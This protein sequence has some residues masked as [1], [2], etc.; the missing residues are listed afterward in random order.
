MEGV[1]TA[2]LSPGLTGGKADD[3][4]L[5]GLIEHQIAE[6]VQGLVV[7]AAAGEFVLHTYDERRRLLATVV[8]IVGGRVPVIAGILTPGT[9]EAEEEAVMAQAAGADG[10]MVL[11]PFFVSPSPRHLLRH[12]HS[13][14][15]ASSLPIILYNNPGRTAIN[16]DADLLDE[17]S[18]LEN[19]VGIKECDRDLG[20]VAQKMARTGERLL[21]LSGDDDLLLPF[22]SIGGVG[23]VMAGSNLMPALCVRAYRAFR[24]GDVV[25][26]RRIFG[27]ILKVVALYKGPDHPGPLK[28]LVDLIGYGVGEAR[29]PLGGLSPAVHSEAE[30]VLGGLGL[31][32]SQDTALSQAR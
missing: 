19:V 31:I 25:E 13:V 23:A 24:R 1:L 7:S 20:R 6:G 15:L 26:A 3:R 32:P 22:L 28:M 10:L 17:L 16:M 2:L 5:A 4:R 11:T 30:R 12:F 29:E 8:G 27:H 9:R 14:S 18:D 21:Y